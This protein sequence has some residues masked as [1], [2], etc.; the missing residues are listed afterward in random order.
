MNNEQNN[1]QNGLGNTEPVNQENVTS[2]E[3]NVQPNVQA[4]NVQPVM[5]EQP[6]QPVPTVENSNNVVIK[7]KILD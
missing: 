1:V 4:E 5:P 2:V 6:V 7:R 3:N